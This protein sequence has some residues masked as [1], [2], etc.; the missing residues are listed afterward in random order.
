MH[1]SALFCHQ[2]A[3][4]FEL[5]LTF[6]TLWMCSVRVALTAALWCGAESWQCCLSQFGYHVNSEVWPNQ[7][8]PSLD[9]DLNNQLWTWFNTYFIWNN[10]IN[11]YE[12]LKQSMSASPEIGFQGILY[13]N[14]LLLI[15]GLL[16]EVWYLL[17]FA[18]VDK[19]GVTFGDTDDD[20]TERGVE[21]GRNMIWV[22]R[23]HLLSL[24]W[25]VLWHK[26]LILCLKANHEYLQVPSVP[27]QR[28][29]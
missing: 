4:R 12:T 9:Y 20:K 23:H 15:N 3:L 22:K 19:Q 14:I 18:W 6:E 26:G 1:Y 25:L 17:Y 5:I 21:A 27:F 10:L 7:L 11:L 8:L 29:P 13:E 2:Y 28:N 24:A 16:S